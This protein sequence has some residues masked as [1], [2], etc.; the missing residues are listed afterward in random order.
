MPSVLDTSK[1]SP[2]RLL[3]FVFTA[4]GG[5]LIALGSLQT[6]AT[7]GIAA[8]RA[9]VLDTAIPGVDTGE[10]KAT[11]AIGIL[12]LVGI[13]ALRVAGSSGARRAIGVAIVVL[14][15]GAL[16]IGIVDLVKADTRFADEGARRMVAARQSPGPVTIAAS[17][18]FLAAGTTVEIGIGLWS[19][20][21][22]GAVG[23]LGGLLDLA[24]VGQQRLA[25]AG[26]ETDAPA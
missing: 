4:V 22:G 25:E 5:L 20:I 17:T 18:D 16:A 15:L 12:L 1:P 11:L 8:D 10:G 19:V 23:V 6:W 14:S 3:G 2:L 9:G 24:W 7:V 21:V 26:A 13:V